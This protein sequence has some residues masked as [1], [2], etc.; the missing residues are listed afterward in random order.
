MAD[1]EGGQRRKCLRTSRH[2]GNSVLECTQAGT[3][4]IDK[5]YGHEYKG[6]QEGQQMANHEKASSWQRHQK[7]ASGRRG[8]HVR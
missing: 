6:T 3:S 8:K 4:F 5:C 1:E 7:G 2:R